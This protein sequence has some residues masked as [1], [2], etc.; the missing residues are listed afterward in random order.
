MFFFF[1]FVFFLGESRTL[2]RHRTATAGRAPD[3]PIPTAN[4]VCAGQE[5]TIPLHIPKHAAPKN[6]SKVKARVAGIGIVGAATVAG[7]M[8]TANTAHAASG[9]DAVAQ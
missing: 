1:L 5:R 4:P 8:A 7:G 6:H 2:G 3:S 9:W